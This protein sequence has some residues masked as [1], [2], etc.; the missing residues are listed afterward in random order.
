MISSFSRSAKTYNE[1]AIPQNEVAYFLSQL[2]ESQTLSGN[3]LDAGCGTG[4]LSRHLLK[5][6]QNINI[7]GVD[8]S[9]DMLNLYQT[10]NPLTLYSDMESLPF[11]D[12][13]FDHTL[14]SFSLH[15]TDIL[16]SIKEL[17]RVSSKYISFALPIDG[18]LED[19]KFPFPCSEKIF[20]L[21][22]ANNVSITHWEC[23]QVKIPFTNMDLI[24]YFHYTGTSINSSNRKGLMNHEKLNETIKRFQDKEFYYIIL[25]VVGKK[26]TLAEASIH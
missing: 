9:Q 5:R 10:V 21:L 17:I 26:I 22:E 12:E 2:I 20:Q 16:K 3:I 7:L 18:S 4:L 13:H 6:D 24:K 11:V 8:I 23:H 19:F 1:W 25:Y 15:W 14:S